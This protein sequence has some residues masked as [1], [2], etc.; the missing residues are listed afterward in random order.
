M[1]GPIAA[2]AGTRYAAGAS[3]SA[4][5]SDAI[6]WSVSAETPAMMR[7]PAAGTLV[8]SVPFG[9]DVGDC[10]GSPPILIFTAQ[11]PVFAEKESSFRPR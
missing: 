6:A 3:V 5:T 10:Y 7:A 4:E 9:R 1:H 11:I 8:E 2:R